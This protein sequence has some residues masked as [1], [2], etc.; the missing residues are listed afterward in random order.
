MSLAD[1]AI[2][3]SRFAEHRARARMLALVWGG[4]FATLV[5]IASVATEFRMGALIDFFPGL[6]RY[7]DRMVPS[8]AERPVGD[9]MASW[10]WNI[11]LWLSLLWDTILIAALA[12]L[13]G[14][15]GALALC[16]QASR[17]LTTGPVSFFI[18]K[19]S[20]EIA[21]SVPDIVFAL[22][23]VAAFGI[24][25]LAG[26]L[27]VAIHA[28][29]ALGKL[30]SEINENVDLETLEG[31]RSTG[32]SRLD[33]LAQ[34]VLPQVLPAYLSYGLL[35]FEIN[36][37]SAAIIGFVGAGGIGQELYTSIRLFAPHNVGAIMILIVAVVIIT[38]IVCGR[39][40]RRIIGDPR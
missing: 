10:F 8:F 22:I 33:I 28:M 24:G 7:L 18:A 39:L 31:L 12:T 36:V 2:F 4:G 21:R 9:V 37:R 35:R 17:N 13:L 11:G 32:A 16:F 20:L 30:F 27:A 6:L 34:G 29:G 23:F 1:P 26:I 14:T 25:P 19:R 38:D 15:A 40:R 3:E 5:V